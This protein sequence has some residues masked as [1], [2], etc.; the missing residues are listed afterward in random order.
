MNESFIAG[1]SVA[2]IFYIIL[3]FTYELGRYLGERK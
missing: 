1:F 3:Y 2:T